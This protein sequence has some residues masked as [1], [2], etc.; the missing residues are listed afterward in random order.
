MVYARMSY[1]VKHGSNL[2]EAFKSL[3]GVLTGDTASPALWNVYFADLEQHITTDPDDIILNGRA[4]SHVEQADDVALFSTTLA[5]LQRKVDQFFGWCCVNFM[6]ISISKSRWMLFGP[7]PDTICELRVGVETIELV[8]EYKYVGVIFKSTRRSIFANHYEV[9]ATKARNV[10]N[11]S[12]AVESMIGYIP[13]FEG[14][15]LY[16]ARID[17]HLTFGC[18]VIPDVDR[19]LLKLLEDVQHKYL[20]RLLGIGSRSMLAVLF[21]ETGIM[22]VAFRRALLALGYLRYLLQLPPSHF[23][24]AA[25]LDSL[26]LAADSHPCWISDLRLVLS[27]LPVPVQLDLHHLQDIETFGT[28]RDTLVKACNMYLQQQI[29]DST[30]CHLLWGR[31]E[32]DEDGKW[33][34][35]S[36]KFRHYLSVPVPAHRKALTRFLLSDHLLGVERLRHDERYRPRIPRLFRLCRF[37]RAAVEDE[38]HAVLSCTANLDLMRLRQDFFRD[39][40]PL[41]DKL[42]GLRQQLSPYDFLLHLVR[43]R[44]I[45]R[46]MAKYIYDVFA[47]YEMV[48]PYVPP[49]YLYH[50]L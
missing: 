32:K 43:H 40:Y 16:M 37:C 33:N 5:G 22:P 30:K 24:R 48:L 38:E 42:R 7:F 6:T 1:V 27:R 12:F 36:S 47:I 26:Q 19:S 44:G 20:R 3:I 11:V 31:K 45:V 21:T 18:E 41:D 8:D 23:A 46:R 15:R 35:S 14:K 9:K 13:P 4:I 29:D 10:A 25:Y 2:T 49:P 50:P 17:P 34:I 39:I 28:V